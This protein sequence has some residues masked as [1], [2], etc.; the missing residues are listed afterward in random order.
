VALNKKYESVG[1]KVKFMTV[2]GGLHGNFP[3]DENKKVND[4]IMA[5]LKENGL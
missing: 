2:P 1:A 4:A 3:K 5:F